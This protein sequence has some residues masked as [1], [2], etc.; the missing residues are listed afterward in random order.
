MQISPSY[1]LHKVVSMLDRA[2]DKKLRTAYGISY[3]RA[4]FLAVIG[5]EGPL[6]QH[7]LAVALGYSDAA[8]SLMV[9]ELLRDD[10]IS[11][12]HSPTNARQRIIALTP[13][14]QRLADKIG[15]FLDE[16]FARL[17]A[18]A[19]V[20]LVAYDAMTDRILTILENKDAGSNEDK[21]P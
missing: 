12:S 1:R 10:Y 15:N 20:D 17:L 18:I 3:K 4:L 6:T 2:A 14:G 13:R 8:V 11:V 16:E 5:G 19:G 9:T 21:T 7:S